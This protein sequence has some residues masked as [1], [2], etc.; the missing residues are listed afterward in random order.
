MRRNVNDAEFE[1]EVL[2]AGLPVLVFFWSV[3]PGMDEALDCELEDTHDFYNGELKVV[4]INAELNPAACKVCGVR[5][6][7]LILIFVEGEVVG[8]FEGDFSLDELNERL[9]QVMSAELERS[10]EGWEG[11]EA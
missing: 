2:Q 3:R 5:Y 7:P 4:N 6:L 11:W 1:R 8:R 10:L 9:E